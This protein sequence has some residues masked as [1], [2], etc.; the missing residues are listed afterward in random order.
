MAQ[1]PQREIKNKWFECEKGW[2]KI[3]REMKGIGLPE[4]CSPD[5][6]VDLHDIFKRHAEKDSTWELEIAHVEI[7]APGQIQQFMEL[8]IKARA[9][10]QWLSA[11]IV[12]YKER[13]IEVKEIIS[14]SMDQ[15][16]FS[17]E[18]T[19]EDIFIKWSEYDKSHP[20]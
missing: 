13:A 19:C 20:L 10:L 15:H 2:E 1:E 8:S 11:K 18:N 4:F 17:Y 3:N 5:E 12:K 14:S 16:R 9:V 7:M 6:F